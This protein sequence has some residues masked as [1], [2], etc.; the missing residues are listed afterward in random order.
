MS[1]DFTILSTNH[2]KTPSCQAPNSPYRIAW[3]FNAFES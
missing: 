1:E 2:A 3:S